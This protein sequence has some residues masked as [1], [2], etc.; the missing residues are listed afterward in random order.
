MQINKIHQR[1]AFA[2]GTWFVDEFSEVFT[3]AVLVSALGVGYRFEIA[4]GFVGS[5]LYLTNLLTRL[6]VYR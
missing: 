5:P 1:S 2:S 3:G 4:V 6:T